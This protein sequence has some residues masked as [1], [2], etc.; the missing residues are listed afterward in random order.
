[1]TWLKKINPSVPVVGLLLALTAVLRLINIA[2]SP[3]RLDDEGTYVAQ[4]F[5]MMEWGEL[6]HYT[7]W[8]DHPP[9]GWLQ[10]GLWSLLT[11]PGFGDNAVVAGRY[12]MV[13]AATVGAFLLWV[14]SRRI[15][16]SRWAAAAA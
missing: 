14:L 13:V 3:I 8:Y 9:V 1:M 12:L 7:Y 2:G 16:F 15:G 6:A 10:L 4:A 11:G 5:A